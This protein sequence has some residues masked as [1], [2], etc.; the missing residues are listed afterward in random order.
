LGCLFGGY[1][2]PFFRRFGFSLLT[3][4]KLALTVPCVSMIAILFVFRAPNAYWALFF[5]CIGTFSHQAICATLLSLPADLMPK[6]AVGTSLG[7][8]GALGFFGAMVSTEIVGR[9]AKAGSYG[10]VFSMLAFLDLI[11][12]AIVWL[13]VRSSRSMSN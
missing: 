7:L 9:L 3:T 4:R 1:L 13:F 5:F 6:R 2:S 8:T 10:P 11:A 12:A